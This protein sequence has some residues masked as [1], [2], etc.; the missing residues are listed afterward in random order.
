[1]VLQRL[2]PI[3]KHDYLTIFLYDMQEKDAGLFL[4]VNANINKVVTIYPKGNFDE[5]IAK[6]DGRILLY[7]K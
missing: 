3:G 7:K 2:L 6:Q 4:N 1:M 5:Y